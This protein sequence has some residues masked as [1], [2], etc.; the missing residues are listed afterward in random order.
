MNAVLVA[1]GGPAGS[2]AAC[3][4]AR[5][6]REVTLIEREAAPAHKICG[7]FLS[8]EAQLYL[9]RLGVDLPALGA[10]PITHLGLGR[11]R[12]MT[13]AKLP[14]R[15]MG[16][17]RRRLDEALLQ[18]AAQTGVRV[19]RGRTIRSLSVTGGAVTLAVEGMEPVRAATCLLATG[20]HDLRGARRRL[21]R[22]ADD[23]VGFKMHLALAPDQRAALRGR[24]DIAMLRDGYAGLQLI[25]DGIATLCFL[26]NRAR[27][28]SVGEG[29]S[30]LLASLQRESPHL[31][32]RLSGAMPLLARPLSIFR[33]PYGFVHEAA[34][35]DPPGLFRLGDQMAV[36]PS[37]S[38]DGISMALHTGFAA[39][40]ALLAGGGAAA[41]HAD[42]RN[43]LARPVRLASALYHFGSWRLGP[44]RLGQSALIGLG[45][46]APAVLQA[47][48]GATRVPEA[49]LQPL[50]AGS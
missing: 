34:A 14:F 11:G 30:A 32:D 2:A 44:W 25:E 29:W 22:A 41:F 5:A 40:A 6:G 9:A 37:F 38:G 43:T 8:R 33:V 15:G 23:L 17:S 20:K 16:L 24:V 46:L 13:V 28:R 36:I 1:G 26:V 45:R 35:D 39:A 48:T 27:L 19:L 31:G 12:A 18:R 7:E 3:L 42:M 47:A 10:Q 4:L 21:A 49:A 50:L